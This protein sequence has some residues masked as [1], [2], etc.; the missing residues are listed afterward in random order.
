[1]LVSYWLLHIL[2]ILT[3]KEKQGFW[4]KEKGWEGGKDFSCFPIQLWNDPPLSLILG[5]CIYTESILH[6]NL[7]WAPAKGNPL[8]GGRGGGE[9][10]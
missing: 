6:L 5:G 9:R 7:D 1:M 3:E 10:R 2:N 4:R 8:S